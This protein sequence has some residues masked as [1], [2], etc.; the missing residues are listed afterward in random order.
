MQTQST[1]WIWITERPGSFILAG[2]LVTFT[3]ALLFLFIRHRRA[4]MNQARSGENRVTFI[5]SLTANGFDAKI[6]RTTYHYLREKQL[7]SLSLAAQDRLDEDLG[8]DSVD[9]EGC[10][11]DLMQLNGRLPGAA[12]AFPAPRTVQD[13]VR[14]IQ[15]APRPSEMAAA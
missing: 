2:A 6:A 8:L 14:Y 3:V 7:M 5:D 9:V 11:R 1:S 15:G 12:M 13:L 4:V 10:V